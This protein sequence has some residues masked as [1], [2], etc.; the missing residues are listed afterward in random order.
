MLHD[1]TDRRNL[2]AQHYP[3]LLDIY[4]NLLM[5]VEQADMWWVAFDLVL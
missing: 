2:V 3:D 5:P 4:D 1:S